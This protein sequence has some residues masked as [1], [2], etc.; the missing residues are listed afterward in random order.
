MRSAIIAFSRCRERGGA[1][2]S[3]QRSPPSGTGRARVYTPPRAFREGAWV[4]GSSKVDGDVCELSFRL[5]GL[6]ATLPNAFSPWT[7]R[8]R[9]RWVLDGLFDM[10]A[11]S[12]MQGRD[13]AVFGERALLM[14]VAVPAGGA[15]SR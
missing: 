12:E 14:A 9:V 15:A 10:R 4:T 7:W 6:D 8:R 2:L 13:G 3:A 11:C 5:D 1:I